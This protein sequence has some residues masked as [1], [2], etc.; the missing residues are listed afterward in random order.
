MRHIISQAYDVMLCYH[1][2]N[3]RLALDQDW[4][5]DSRT[6][7]FGNTFV[8]LIQMQIPY[9]HTLLLLLRSMFTNTPRCYANA[10]FDGLVQDYSNS[11]ANAL[12]LLQSCT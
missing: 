2:I 5:L 7:M 6:L 1:G 9:T 8:W 12:D 4:L 10:H 11:I 3:W